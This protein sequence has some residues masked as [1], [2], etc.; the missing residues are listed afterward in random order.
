LTVPILGCILPDMGT[1]RSARGSSA[2]VRVAVADALFS[3][4]QQRV[5]AILFGNSHRSFYAN[6]IIDLANIGTGAI[7]R[8]LGRLEGAELITVN[9]VGNQKH[10]QANASAA[11]FEPLRELVLK[12]SGLAN[13][14]LAALA[15]VATE[16]RAAFVYGS[17]AKGEDS[18]TSDV[19]LMVISESLAYAD[20]FSLLE[21]AA[22]QLGRDVNPTV[23]SSAELAARIQQKNSFVTRVLTQ[24]KIWLIGRAD[25][26]TPR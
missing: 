2:V 19:D 7:Q 20:L 15:P 26:L 5:L 23:Y 3:K 1:N 17:I 22:R 6:E 16:I 11:V 18:A 14:L 12:T 8:E 13:V 4:S 25:D 24:P 10:Y 9:R 21:D